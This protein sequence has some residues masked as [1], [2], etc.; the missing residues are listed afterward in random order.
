MGHL[1]TVATCSLNQWALD[2]EGNADRIIKSIRIA[3]ER[4]ASLRVG[5]EL[6]VTGYGCFD[7]FLEGDTYLHSWEML[8]RILETE[9]TDDILLDIGMPVSHRNVKY[10]CR[11]ICL[12]RKVLLIRPKLW[13]ANDGNY[14]EQRYF[15]AWARPRHVEPFY[16][17]R[18]IQK[19]TGQT[20]CPFGDAVISTPDTCFGAET[21]EELFTPNSPHIGMSLDG[22]EIMTNSSGSH[23]E[24]RKLYRRIDLMK[25]ATMKCGGVYLYSNPQGCDG[26]RLY[27][28]GCAM[29][30][31]NGQI[32]AQGTQFSLTDVEVV[33]ATVD[34]EEV[35]AHRAQASRGMQAVAA[36]SYQ[37]IE[38]SKALS[39]EAGVIDPHLMPTKEIKVRY[40][41][42]E[43]EIAL[44][45]ACWLWD[46][47]RRS[48]TAG[49]FLPLSGGIDSCATATIVHSM[50]RLVA[51][52]AAN[53]NEEVIKDARRMAG[54]KE[55]SDWLPT[56]PKEFAGRIFHTCYMG[57]EN[58]SKETR[59]RARHLAEAIGAYH[60]DLNMDDLVRAVQTLFT[61]VTGK[62]PEY[63]VHGGSQTENL[64]LQ[65]IQ[66]RL[67]MVIAYLF[68]QLLP[69]VRGKPGGLLVLGSANVDE[70][71][72]GYFTKYDCSSADVNPIGG[73]SKTDLKRFIAYARDEFDLPILHEFLEATPTAELEPI[74]KDYVQSDEIDMGMTY[75]ELSVFGRLRKV[76]KCGPYSMFTKLVHEWGD[77]L[78][79]TEIATKV[80]RFFFY[81]AINRHKMTTLTPSYHAEAYSPDDNRFDLRPFLYNAG[82]SW[83]NKKIDEAA[84]QLEELDSKKD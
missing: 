48:K 9:G 63:K 30:L 52:A 76:E 5:P 23:H 84:K 45:P 38:A 2:F 15:T 7:H 69:W 54:E 28:D 72:R 77:K 3:K 34:L 17:P 19:L 79:P 36:P 56:D 83:Q 11:V 75:D 81:H 37:R 44:G 62:K 64:A 71:L 8:G 53:G 24:L 31:V 67:R 50:C 49:Y 80:K 51:Q 61:F 27:Y 1:V 59:E 35:R 58:S 33:T 12:N 74:T 6:E 65:N 22:V 43:E 14:R 26:D 10:N 46:Y 70:A 55:D 42:P 40:H 47:L 20:M 68:A 25:E 16:L 82:W 18:M 29:I 21:C 57:T 4:G 78:S 41:T 73:I 66:A 13:L 32:V 39:K 60:V